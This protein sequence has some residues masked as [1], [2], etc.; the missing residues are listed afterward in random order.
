M[1]D[2]MN[3]MIGNQM[4]M[5]GGDAVYRDMVGDNSNGAMGT[6][7]GRSQGAAADAMSDYMQGS[8]SEIQVG[9]S[10]M[11]T[12]RGYEGAGGN[13][14]PALETSDIS[15]MRMDTGGPSLMT[16]SLSSPASS[17]PMMNGPA[18]TATPM[19]SGIGS[20][21]GVGA[22]LTQQ[23]MQIGA[24]AAAVAGIASSMMPGGAGGDLAAGG[25][26]PSGPT[27]AKAPGMLEKKTVVVSGGN[28]TMI[29]AA[30]RA[31]VSAPSP[32]T[33][34]PGLSSINS[35]G[36]QHGEVKKKRRLKEEE[37]EEGIPDREPSP[38]LKGISQTGNIRPTTP[39]K[40]ATGRREKKKKTVEEQ[41][42]GKLQRLDE[43]EFLRLVEMT[44]RQIK[45]SPDRD[46]R[47]KAH[48]K[49]SILRKEAD[50]RI[51]HTAA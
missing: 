9:L 13:I 31:P 25:I 36:A 44:D 6:M 34:D 11:D 21:V 4:G 15:N 49:M 18:M 33:A 16:P 30:T 10:M 43:D 38:D 27:I 47:L 8:Q 41:A 22:D 17:S 32:K 50:R 37:D 23:P 7:V 28:K 24:G 1:N 19:M 46:E 20:P 35:A 2:A 42:L 5:G 26:K 40:M 14:E 51:Q 48:C 45:E 3:T 29:G 12:M 39:P